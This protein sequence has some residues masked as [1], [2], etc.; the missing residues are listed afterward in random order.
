[1][2]EERRRLQDLG[3]LVAE[4]RGGR[5][6]SLRQAAEE[7]GVA[8]NTLARIERGFIPDLETFERVTTWIG[9]PAAEFF[10]EYRGP[11]VSTP[12]AI[13]AHLRADP[14]LSEEAASRIA[15]ILRDLYGTLAQR[16]SAVAVHLRAAKSFKPAAAASLGLLLNELRNAIGGE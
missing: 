13:A 6:L 9:I 10:D 14:A 2:S 1:L 4:Y 15:A 16:D 12:E 3:R 5:T 8:F 7:C 11:A